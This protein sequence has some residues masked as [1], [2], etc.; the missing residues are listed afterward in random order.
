MARIVLVR[1]DESELRRVGE[2]G[3]LVVKFV[4]THANIKV[5]VQDDVGGNVRYSRAEVSN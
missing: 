1:L 4:V 5:E 3:G 2:S